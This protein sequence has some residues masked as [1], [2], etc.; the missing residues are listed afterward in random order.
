MRF[1]CNISCDNAAFEPDEYGDVKITTGMRV[2]VA[3][4]LRKLAVDIENEIDEESFS[5]TLRD[6]NGNKIGSARLED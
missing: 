2:E 3:R 1:A 4:I 5:S 6:G